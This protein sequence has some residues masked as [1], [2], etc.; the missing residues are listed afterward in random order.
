MSKNDFGMANSVDLVQTTP[1]EKFDLGLHCLLRP[2][3]TEILFF[4]VTYLL[5]EMSNT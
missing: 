2:V 5:I 3:L 1:K 4:S